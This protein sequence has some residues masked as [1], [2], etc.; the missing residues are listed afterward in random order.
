MERDRGTENYSNTQRDHKM[1]RIYA[2]LYA[3][4]TKLI[5]DSSVNDKDGTSSA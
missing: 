5:Q 2:R 1:I 3:Y 4:G